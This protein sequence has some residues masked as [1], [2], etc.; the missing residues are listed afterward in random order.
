M[1]FQNYLIVLWYVEQSELTRFEDSWSNL[2]PASVVFI[3]ELGENM[4]FTRPDIY[5]P[6]ARSIDELDHNELSSELKVHIWW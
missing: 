1:I 5:D 2:F 3:C 4:R 6:N